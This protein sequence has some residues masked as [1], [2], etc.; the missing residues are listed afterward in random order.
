MWTTKG[1][2]SK[3]N[4]KEAAAVLVIGFE[5]LHAPDIPEVIEQACRHSVLLIKS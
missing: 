2:W 4:V 3:L 1:V 5:I